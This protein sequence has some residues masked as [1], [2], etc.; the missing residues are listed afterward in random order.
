LFNYSAL[1]PTR[2]PDIDSLF[3]VPFE[4]IVA[5]RVLETLASKIAGLSLPANTLD[6]PKVTAN[7]QGFDVGPVVR[8][9]FD[10]LFDERLIQV[11]LHKGA[12]WAVNGKFEG[13]MAKLPFCV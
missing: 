3:Q 11:S 9:G 2:E 8:W 12:E 4:N 6:A 13:R 10:R 7:F 1:R 5:P